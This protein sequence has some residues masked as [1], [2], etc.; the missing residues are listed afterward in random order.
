[1]AFLTSLSKSNRSL[2]VWQYFGYNVLQ[3]LCLPTKL[4][5]SLP[6]PHVKKC[7]SDSGKKMITPCG[8]Q[9][10]R[11]LLPDDWWPFY[12]H[13][14]AERANIFFA[15]STL[16][17]VGIFFTSFYLFLF[18]L[19]YLFWS[20]ASIVYSE[21]NLTAVLLQASLSSTFIYLFIFLMSTVLYMWVG[22]L[23]Y[24]IYWNL[25]HGLVISVQRISVKLA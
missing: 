10:W 23:Y 14:E 6:L 16:L 24:L 5:K 18:S 1:M 12:R 9:R 8:H 15:R 22:S 17:D 4:H 19:L 3:G 13:G 21:T 2:L 11:I 7:D 25:K 20:R